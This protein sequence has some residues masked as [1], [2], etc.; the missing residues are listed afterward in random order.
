MPIWAGE[1]I[2]ESVVVCGGGLSGSECALGLAMQGKNVKVVDVL[3]VEDLCRDV[4]DLARIALFR[5]MEDYGVERVQ[6]S[7]D[8]SPARGVIGDSSRRTRGGAAR[9]HGRH[10][11]RP[12]AGPRRAIEPLLDV[13]P[14]EL[15]G[16][17]LQQRRQHLQRQP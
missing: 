16:G 6:G 2:G 1:P 4:V 15:P 12:P 8:A 10:G 9:R 11:V 14:R 5:L 13:D 17:R 3:P 7:V